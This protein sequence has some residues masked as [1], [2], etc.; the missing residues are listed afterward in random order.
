MALALPRFLP[1]AYVWN[2]FLASARDVANPIP[3]ELPV[4]I[5]TFSVWFEGKLIVH[6]LSLHIITLSCSSYPSN[7][8]YVSLQHD[9]NNQQPLFTAT[10]YD[11]QKIGLLLS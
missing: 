11:L 3:V 10:N 7:C 6:M 4:T 2:P 8:C 1:V 9:S 5:A